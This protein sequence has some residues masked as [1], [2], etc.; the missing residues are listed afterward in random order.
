MEK[1][2][3]F[4][5]TFSTIL[6]VVI[7]TLLIMG[8]VYA[9]TSIGEN[10]SVGTNLTAGGTF[11][12]SGNATTSGYLV[13]GT[14]NPT[15]DLGAGDLLIG[16]SATSTNYFVIG[17]PTANYINYSGGDLIAQGDVEVD[18]NVF[19][20]GYASTTGDLFV[21]GGT[22]DLTTTT[23]TTTIGAFVRSSS[24][25]TTT[26]SVGDTQSDISV[27]C[28][29]MVTSGGAY[30]RAIIDPVSLTFNIKVGRCKD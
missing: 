7:S 19:I 2:K 22:F 17:A 6:T 9:S 8:A 24:I 4:K 30:A 1:I 28:I 26:L 11:V 23:A 5:N 13:V 29:E 10:V 25:A 14:T 20:G 15:K 12:A 16:D 3:L 18:S 21:S 27:G